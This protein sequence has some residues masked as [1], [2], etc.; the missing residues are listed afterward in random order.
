MATGK[1][2]INNRHKRLIVCGGLFGLLFCLIVQL[3]CTL[4]M[5]AGQT[6]GAQWV[7]EICR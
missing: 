5:A 6:R 3:D 1:L 7:L 2:Q 4:C